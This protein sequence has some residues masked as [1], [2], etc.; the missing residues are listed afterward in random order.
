MRVIKETCPVPVDI[1]RDT[2][3]ILD[4]FA[5]RIPELEIKP[6]CREFLTVATERATATAVASSSAL[7][8]IETVLEQF[9]LRAWFDVV[10]SGEAVS[11][12]KPAPDIFLAAADRLRVAPRDCVVLED[13]YAGVQAARAAG[14]RVIA[15]PEESDPRFASLADAV[16]GDLRA[17]LQLLELRPGKC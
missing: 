12:S 3:T 6:G 11:R 14:M 16:V 17:A 7:R 1:E 4:Q 13:A 2:R 9:A 5:A 8:L 15:V 10:V